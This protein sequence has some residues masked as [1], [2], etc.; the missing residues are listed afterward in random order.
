MKKSK[1]Q[2][3]SPKRQ[4]KMTV[5]GQLFKHLGLQMYSGAVPAISELISNAY[6]AMAKN[7]WITIPTNRPIEATDQIIVKDDGHG[8]TFDE[9]NDL[10]LSVGRNR[11]SG[12]SEWTTA[13]NRLKP[14]KVQGRKGI[15]K[16][17]GFG[18][19]D[20]I[21]VRSARNK[22]VSHFALDF[23][24][25]TQSQSFADTNGY[26]PE[27]LADDARATKERCKRRRS[28][29]RTKASVP[30]SRARRPR[31]RPR[32]GFPTAGKRAVC[33]VPSR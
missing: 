30:A 18:I 6:D 27:A 16:L 10:Y 13:Y 11:R 24:A 15:G 19:A 4:Y 5:A 7:V 12:A 21:E 1:A 22:E 20:R 29:R 28:G 25:L 23:N 3:G 31:T 2:Q 8:M 32:P 17:A 9:S 14:R 33:V 26:L